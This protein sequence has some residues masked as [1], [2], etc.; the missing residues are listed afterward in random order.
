MEVL[1]FIDTKTVPDIVHTYSPEL[2]KNAVPIIIDNGSYTCRVGWATSSEPL[3]QFRNLIAKP[4]RERL[5]K[6]TI[7]IPQTP[8]LQVGND[9]V[10]IEAVRFQLKTQFDRN[11][12][13]HFEA[14]E[15]LLDYAFSHLGIN[16]EDCVPHPI[17]CTEAVLNP[18]TSRQLMSELL[19]ECYNVPGICYGIDS[20]FG[21]H[22][23]HKPMESA[24]IVNL[25]YQCCHIIPVL[26]N[27]TNFEN[28]RRLNTGG[29]HIVNF[30]HRLLQLKYPVHATAIT[31]SRAEE[32]LH[33]VCRVAVD[34]R[35]ELKKWANAEFYENNVKKIQLPFTVNTITSAVTLEQQKERKRELARRLI[36]INARK[37]E[38]RLAEDEEK[39]GQLL[40]IKEMIEL[41]AD[42]ETIERTLTEFQIKNVLDLEKTIFT[43]NTKIEKTKQ[44]ILA[45][46]SNIDEMEEPQ[47]K[48]SKFSKMA[49]ESDKEMYVFV[50]NVRKLKQEILTKK[51]VRKQR[52]Q[53]MAKRRTAAGQE[54]MRIIS[55]LARKEKGND[56]FGMRDEDWD[57][58]KTISKD[59]GDSDSEAE[60]EKLLE[61]DEILRTHEPSE[62]GDCSQP[63]EA[64]Q[65][66]IGVEMFRG[67]E[68]IFKPYMIG[69]QEAGLSEVIAY[70]LSLFNPDDQ[71]KLA[72]KVVVTGG[73]ADLP[74]LRDRLLTDLISVRPFK[75]TVNITIINNASLSSWYGARNFAQ[76]AEFMDTLV[77]KKM[78]QEMGAEYFKVHK[79]SNPF[80]A[81]PTSIAVEGDLCV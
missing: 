60:N 43:L 77:T 52:K 55:Q 24:L 34:Y 14:Q 63:G 44:K 78:Y 13:T 49:F 74:G 20:I 19:F 70:V 50:Q 21:Y 65:L 38:E 81:S 56:D 47:A 54:R 18:N 15:H 31:V 72:S 11:V 3:I 27:Q 57:I 7:E 68:L 26:N 42:R 17:L 9:I 23:Y 45:A 62:L 59:G 5:K 58:Y 37:R 39:I 22:N 71:L 32:L 35:E 69:S 53:D 16:T 2:K 29:F 6:D 67:P 51:M 76:S 33:N 66:H 25:G 10:N 73:L 75:S 46:S 64:H 1:Q 61:F 30:L 8:Q 28:T 12:V 40:D 79:Y 48:Q 41:G 80:N 36:E 4:R